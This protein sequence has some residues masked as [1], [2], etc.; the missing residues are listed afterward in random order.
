MESMLLNTVHRSFKLTRGQYSRSTPI[1]IS[2]VD[3]FDYSRGE[4][5]RE[6]LTPLRV[7]EV[8]FHQI[9]IDLQTHRLLSQF[10][11][12]WVT[13]IFI[14]QRS[15]ESVVLARNRAE[16]DDVCTRIGGNCTVWCG[17]DIKELYLVSGFRHAPHFPVFSVAD[18]NTLVTEESNLSQ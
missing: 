4:P 11:D 12:E 14:N 15:I 5:P 13:R 2:A 1:I 10:S 18:C 7:L 6:Y 16:G 3:V 8:K 9:M 17:T